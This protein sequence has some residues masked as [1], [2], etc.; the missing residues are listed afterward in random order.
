M[1]EIEFA[2]ELARALG[3]AYRVQLTDEAGR[4]LAS[5]GRGSGS[6]RPMMK[7]PLPNSANAL[8]IGID[9]DAIA[10]A[11]RL[12][13]EL[14]EPHTF[15]KP[16]L[17]AFAHLDGALDQLITQGEAHIGRP[18]GEMSRTE[19]QLLVRFLDDRGA[20]SLRKS[21]ERVADILGV[22]RFTVYN[23]LDAVRDK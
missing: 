11:E 21:V 19:K 2:E 13:H 15:A 9:L 17:G 22:S 7:I 14:A 4:V 1:T 12:L 8:S 5:F 6:K 18:L 3:L 10:A 20:F 16:P 23:Y